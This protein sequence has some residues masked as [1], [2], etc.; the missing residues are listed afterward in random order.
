MLP[1]NYCVK[2]LEGL[3]VQASWDP[4]RCVH[5]RDYEVQ[6]KLD[7]SPEL[8]EIESRCCGF[9][10]FIYYC[11]RTEHVYNAFYRR[12][13]HGFVLVDNEDFQRNGFDGHDCSGC[14]HRDPLFLLVNHNR[15]LSPENQR[16]TA[17]NLRLEKELFNFYEDT[18][19]TE[20]TI[21][22]RNI[23]I[24]KIHDMIERVWSGLPDFRVEFFGSTRTRLANDSSD[25]D[26]AIVIPQYINADRETLKHLKEMRNSIYNMH[27]LASKLREIGM[28]DV[29]PIQGARV[30]ICK[31]VDP[32]TGLRC[33]INASSSLGVENSQL[34]DEYRKL[35]TRVGPFLYALKYFVKQRDINDNQKGTLSSYAYCLL[36]IY[37]L[38]N[39]EHDSPIIPNL[40]NF[41]SNCD[42]CRGY[43]CKIGTTNHIVEKQQ[44]RYHDC[45]EVVSGSKYQVKK[46][47]RRQDCVT[48]RWDGFC[49][50]NL[51][52]IMLDFFKWASNIEN[53]TTH[54]SIRY[55]GMDIPN[56]PNKFFKKSMVI[57]D[58]FILIKNVA[59]SCSEAGLNKIL[60]EFQRGAHLL[61]KTDTTFVDMCNMRS[62]LGSYPQI[63]STTMEVP[64]KFIRPR[65]RK[66]KNQ[67]KQRKQQNFNQPIH[68]ELGYHNYIRQLQQG[69][70]T[71]LFLK[72]TID[73]YTKHLKLRSRQNG[74]NWRVDDLVQILGTASRV[75]KLSFVDFH[76]LSTETILPVIALLPNVK[77]IEFKYCH[78]VSIPL[79]QHKFIA[80]N[81]LPQ[82]SLSSA[83][84][85]VSYVWT[86]FTAKAV[87][88]CLFQQISH[89][90]LGS[91]R[92]KYESANELIV[93]SLPQHCPNIT[94]LTIALPQIEE[95]IICDT[96]AHYGKQLQQLSIK[97]IG[98][99]TLL[100]ISTRALNLQKLAL[101]VTIDSQ[102]EEE[103]DVSPYMNHIVA[104]CKYLESFE[105]ASTQLDQDV[106]NE[107][108][109]A[110]IAC[111]K[112]DVT[113]TSQKR[114]SRA[115]SALMVRQR[116]QVAKNDP[117]SG[118][119]SRQRLPLRRN[120][121]WFGTVSE[122]ALEQRYHYNNS[123]SGRY[124]HQR[125][126]SEQLQLTRS[127]LAR[128]ASA[129]ST[130]NAGLI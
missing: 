111:G 77:H 84:K 23:V 20:K 92:S 2:V 50:D 119:A 78:I 117:K 22:D 66:S 25:L 18:A 75:E 32:E 90:E 12:F 67:A 8:E 94:H 93:N 15:L 11:L 31:F 65:N 48:T 96:I 104:T 38:M 129:N 72:D 27:C 73:S 127:E 29:E 126:N 60:A 128:A 63:S 6:L 125:N 17:A 87:I 14:H 120:S 47:K 64:L 85:S 49:F 109:E 130:L 122:E 46:E 110:I 89:L 69:V 51:G 68:L 118:M 45:I 105:I 83:I 9:N 97:C 88:P 101:R 123:I 24:D 91:N 19:M 3:Y 98:H 36:G 81:A 106:P 102:K 34:I 80:N 42:E 53:L 114:E 37:Y 1:V 54:M 56:V 21:R 10:C 95:P 4:Q 107:I 99:R 86:D 39:H 59:S 79:I 70:K 121:F 100:V 57:Q 35:D 82:R 5:L 58:P 33:D 62:E 44:V 71:N 103:E 124:Q 28:I 112:V 115:R 55:S 61:E 7:Y 13:G 41:K 40:H 113:N 26:L 76:A 16:K 43:G 52:K 30:P 116:N 74:N 108:W